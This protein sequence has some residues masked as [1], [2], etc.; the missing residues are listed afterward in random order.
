MYFNLRNYLQ[1]PTVLSLAHIV[2]RS[3][4]RQGLT[5]KKRDSAGIVREVENKGAPRTTQALLKMTLRAE[6]RSIGQGS[7]VLWIRNRKQVAKAERRKRTREYVTI[8]PWP[9]GG[10][11]AEKESKQADFVAQLAAEHDR[12]RQ[13]RMR[14]AQNRTN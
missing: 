3:T 12:K 2:C 4:N 10:L 9:L 11:D 7:E 13:R 5:L 1:L 8:I 14:Q 6:T